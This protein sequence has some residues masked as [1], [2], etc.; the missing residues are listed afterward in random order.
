MAKKKIDLSGIKKID[1]NGNPIKKKSG[2]PAYKQNRKQQT[3][4]KPL[5]KSMKKEWIYI[6]TETSVLKNVK[7]ICEEQL[8]CDVEFW[9]MAGVLEL[10]GNNNTVIDMEIINID[11]I[12]ENTRNMYKL[13]EESIIAAATIDT[14]NSDYARDFMKNIEAITKGKFL[15]D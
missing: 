11:E 10:I 7:E 12:D 15:E 4:A 8:D 1:N 9:E 5:I 2:K 6:N 14:D 3:T 13:T